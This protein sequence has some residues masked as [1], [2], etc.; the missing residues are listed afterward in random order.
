LSIQPAAAAATA[1]PGPNS[2]VAI[3]RSDYTSGFLHS[4]MNYN[5][6]VDYWR[7]LAQR[8]NVPSLVITD[9]MLENGLQSFD[10][11]VLP[12]AISLSEKERSSIRAFL[13]AGGGV[14]AT[15]ATG[16]HDETGAWKGADFLLELTGADSL[17]F[18][19]RPPPWFVSFPSGKPTTAGA[20]GGFRVQVDSPERL[21][22][23]RLEVDGYWSDVNLFPVDAKLPANFEGALLHNSVGRGRVV[24]YGFQENAAVAGGDDKRMLDATLVDSLAWAGKRT[25]CAVDPW[26]APYS[27][28]AIFVCDVED[29]FYNAAYSAS[30]LQKAQEKGTFFCVANM[31][32]DDPDLIAKLKDAGEVAS[33]GD[34]H[35]RFGPRR[36]L[37]QI[38]HLENSKWRLWQLGGGWVQG[39]HPPFDD[40]GDRTMEALA[41]SHFRYIL[42]G[43]EG[44]TGSNGVLPEILRI[45]QSLGWFHR[46]MKLVSMTRTVDD[47]LHFSPLGIVGLDPTWIVQRALGDFEIIH[48]L[49]GMYLFCFHSQG[50]SA[51]EY[52]GIFP[53]LINEFHRSGTWI[54][55]AEGVA[56]WWELRSHVA[57]SLSNNQA[58]GL[59]LVVKYTGAKPL[60]HVALSVFLPGQFHQ[61][62]ILA[63]GASPP[64]EIA[65]GDVDGRLSVRLGTLQPGTI[66]QYDLTWTQ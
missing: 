9:P 51:P 3:L 26:P 33:H 35:N 58:D 39:F 38:A 5:A 1:P 65:P 62:H 7:N 53:D 23:K 10:V 6:H 11:L 49:G 57:V 37:S 63:V 27:A 44:N 40:F 20:P 47:D 32:K 36:V 16:A 66:S 15:W 25:L 55:T 56:E 31:V 29:E 17:N 45:S 42:I 34:L 19:E 54:A 12:S 24:W 22:A 8:V 30:A 41:A 46:D 48:A 4:S 60:G 61:G 18:T 28:A 2:R 59:R 21:E 13:A 50:F 43:A 64:A 14:I 52:V